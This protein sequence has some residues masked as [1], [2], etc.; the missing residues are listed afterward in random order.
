MSY[1]ERLFERLLAFHCAPVLRKK[2]AANMFHIKKSKFHD[3]QTIITTY[4]RKLN[5]QGLFLKLFQKDKEHVTVYMYYKEMLES[6]LNLSDIKNFLK[7]YHYPYNDVDASLMYLDKRLTTCC[8]Y[9]HEI[10]IFLGYPLC[11]V[12]GFIHQKQ[13]EFCGYWKV[14]QNVDQTSQLFSIYDKCIKETKNAILCGRCIEQL[15][16]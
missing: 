13:C 5:I 11:D 7:N 8:E 16:N 10:G 1:D 2:K 12:L 9:P 3:I 4:N 15:I 6:I 14:Y